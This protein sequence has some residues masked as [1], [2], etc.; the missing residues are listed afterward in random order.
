VDSINGVTITCHNN[1]Q[2][3]VT[4]QLTDRQ[5]LTWRPSGTHDPILAVVKTDAVLSQGVVRFCTA[6]YAY[7]SFTAEGYK[8]NLDKWSIICL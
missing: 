4:L 8:Q 1:N 2:E 6:D 3:S 5:V 7:C